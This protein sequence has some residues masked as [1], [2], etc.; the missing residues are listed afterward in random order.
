LY[1]SVLQSQTYLKKSYL[2]VK[3]P[4]HNKPC[5]K[6]FMF[7]VCI[8]SKTVVLQYVS[9]TMYKGKPTEGS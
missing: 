7:T 4:F 6:N 5:F 9:W 1:W 3:A 8:F 2:Q